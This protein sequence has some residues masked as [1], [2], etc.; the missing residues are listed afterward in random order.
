MTNT[1]NAF[2]LLNAFFYS[3]KL[4]IWTQIL[5]QLLKQGR[6]LGFGGHIFLPTGWQLS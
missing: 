6:T 4:C 2:K 1:K 3:Q 5:L